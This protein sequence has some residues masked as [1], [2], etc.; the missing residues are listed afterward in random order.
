MVKALA[1]GRKVVNSPPGLRALRWR[2]HSMRLFSSF[3]IWFGAAVHRRDGMQPSAQTKERA[4]HLLDSKFLQAKV[5]SGTTPRTYRK[6]LAV[7]SQGDLADSVFQ[8]QE[9]NSS[10][11]ARSGW[12]V[13][14]SC[15][16]TL[17]SPAIRSQWLRRL[18]RKCRRI[19]MNK[20]RKLGL[21]DYDGGKL[22][23]HSSQLHLVRHD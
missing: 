17:G 2:R 8:V 7:F 6:G 13:R 23:V 1:A 20:F 14:Y 22:R 21:I 15:W 10:T 4:E 19:F 16:R 12:R 18:V 11:A 9:A 5:G 3:E